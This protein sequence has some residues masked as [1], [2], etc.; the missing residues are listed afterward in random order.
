MI[1][2]IYLKCIDLLFAL[3]V[4]RDILLKHLETL[5]HQ[6]N[7]KDVAFELKQ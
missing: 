3:D 1:H 4:L 7:L 6:N 5:V 2:D